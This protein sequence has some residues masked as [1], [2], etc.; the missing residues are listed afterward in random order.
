MKTFLKK[1]A[2]ATALALAIGIPTANAEVTVSI[3]A[4]QD[5]ASFLPLASGFGSAG[6]TGGFGAFYIAVSGTGSPPLTSPDLFATNSID[7]QKEGT[8]VGH[9]LEIYVTSQGNTT[10]SPTLGF[11]SGFTSNFLTS[12]W[13][14]TE[15]TF[16][17]ASN[18]LWGTTTL[19]GSATF[20]GP[21]TSAASTAIAMGSGP[22]SVTT[23]YTLTTTAGS[24]ASNATISMA[25]PEPETY[26]MLLAGLGLM[27]F[28]ARRRQRN[29]A[30]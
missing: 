3:G 4:K 10:T 9:T 17:D 20:S 13:S 12:G 23:L 2:L 16:Y 24:G 15:E 29:A 21:A 6:F 19:L 27:G 11:T 5:S 1:A 25:I 30:A 7:V 26:A 28:I 22:Y 18:T 14:I 8:S